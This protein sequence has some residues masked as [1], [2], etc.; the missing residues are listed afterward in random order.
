MLAEYVDFR[1]LREALGLGAI[2]ALRTIYHLP[3]ERLRSFRGFR[4]SVKQLLTQKRGSSEPKGIEI[5][6]INFCSASC[7]RLVRVARE[8]PRSKASARQ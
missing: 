4:R 3:F 7:I 2:N 6:K 1:L 5:E 8:C